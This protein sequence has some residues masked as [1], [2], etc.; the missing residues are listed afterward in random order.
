M[1]TLGS[2][3]VLKPNSVTDQPCET[4]QGH[5]LSEPHFPPLE[6]GGTVLI[7]QESP[8]GEMTHGAQ[9]P[10]HP[11]AEAQRPPPH[12]HPTGRGFLVCLCVDV[13]M[14]VEIWLRAD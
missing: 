14:G 3:C 11:L 4:G 2:D 5:P 12:S 1:W 8:D 6:N 7:L 13:A 9:P 10:G